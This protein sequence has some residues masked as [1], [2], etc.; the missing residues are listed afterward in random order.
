MTTK[1]QV[2]NKYCQGNRSRGKISHQ[3][4]SKMYEC[5]GHTDAIPKW[6]CRLFIDGILRGHAVN[7]GT[8][9][10]AKEVACEQAVEAL[11]I[12]EDD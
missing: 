9:Q 10:L 6:G 2:I 12:N 5:D 1:T 11:G 4:E 3:Q 7:C 8:K